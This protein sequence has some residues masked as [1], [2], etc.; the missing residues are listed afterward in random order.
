MA[1]WV[2]GID[3]GTT[4]TVVAAS[5][6]D[7]P[8]I[9]VFPVE[10]RVAPGTDD[11]RKLLPSALQHEDGSW[12][13]GAYAR[14]RGAEV[15]NRNVASAKSWLAHPGVDRS[16]AIL[17][18]GVEGE[19]KMSPVDASAAVLSHVRQAW[20]RVHADPLIE[21]EVFLTVPASFDE[22]A[23]ALTV[24]AT[25]RAGFPEGSIRLLEEPQAA[26]LDWARIVGASGL[27]ALV[28]DGP[29]E[30][31]VCDVG[32]GTSDFSLIEVGKDTSLRRVAVGDHLLLGGDNVD[33]AIAHLMEKRISGGEALAP[34]RF[35]QLV[36]ASRDAKELLLSRD[37]LQEI[38]VTLGGTGSKLVGG[39]RKATLA[40]S[41][42][43]AILDGFFPMVDRDAKPMRA[44][45]G[46]VAFGLPYASDPAIT[47]HLAAFLTR[48]AKADVALLLNGGAFHAKPIVE[49]V[50]RAIERITGRAPELLE[51]GDP[52]LSVARGAVAHG[53]S[54]HG[55]GARMRGGASR[56]YFIGLDAGKAVCVVPRGTEPEQPQIVEGRTFALA[57]GT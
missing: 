18:W 42:V 49:R 48:H 28:K 38:T 46:L 34:S 35:A 23:R 45:S 51:Q 25:K 2:V 10:Q 52:D 21:Q 26:F 36:Q 43:E 12:I 50:V 19:E 11:A 3:L 14:A 41:E 53:L 47:R 24:E 8:K 27:R 30:V 6:T 37:D 54:F 20:D 5:K 1:R 9:E 31:L 16:A 56:S 44:R 57:L 33:L 7:A 4:N 17:P 40:R 13:V 32:G 29:R 55:H 22:A 15:P 39:A